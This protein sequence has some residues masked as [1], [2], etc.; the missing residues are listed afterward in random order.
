MVIGIVSNR[1]WEKAWRRWTPKHGPSWIIGGLRSCPSNFWVCELTLCARCS[2]RRDRTSFDSMPPCCSRRSAMT[3]SLSICPAMYATLA[4]AHP[5]SRW[6]FGAWGAGW[7]LG[8]VVRSDRQQGHPRRFSSVVRG[9]IPPNQCL[10]AAACLR[11]AFPR[12]RRAKP[13]QMEREASTNLSASSSL[14][15]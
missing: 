13:D 3:G 11:T 15:A 1:L 7:R 5:P 2:V 6:R 10:Q 14:W 12:S 4:S 8:L 9:Y